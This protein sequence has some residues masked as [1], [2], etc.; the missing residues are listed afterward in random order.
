MV[1]YKNKWHLLQ[2][3]VGQRSLWP[4][5]ILQVFWQGRFSPRENFVL[6][7]FFYGNN[8]PLWV[9]FEAIKYCRPGKLTSL[10]VRKFRGYYTLF[11]IG[12]PKILKRF[13]YFDVFLRKY[14]NL[15]NHFS[16][17]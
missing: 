3:Y 5:N 17:I 16:L 6:C 15:F 14:D 9:V 7:K 2:A 10:L 4:W 1:F 8:V 11:K 13:V 12:H